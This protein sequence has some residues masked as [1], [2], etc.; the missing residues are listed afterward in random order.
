MRYEYDQDGC[1]WFAERPVCSRVRGTGHMPCVCARLDVWY[2]AIGRVLP[3]Q[4]P[5][6]RAVPKTGPNPFAA[7]PQTRKRRT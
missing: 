4:G 2:D 6:S 1:V 3:V 5:P 7:R